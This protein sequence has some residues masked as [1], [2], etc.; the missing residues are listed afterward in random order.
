[1]R[2]F[3]QK[4]PLRW[5]A[6]AYVVSAAAVA[7]ICAPAVCHAHDFWLQPNEF[8]LRPD[9]MTPMTMQ[10]GHGPF[11]QRS[12]IQLGR[13]VHFAA[14]AAD[15]TAIDLRGKLHPGDNT[16][17]A[18]LQFRA[19]GTY[20][21]VLETDDRAQSHLPAI[22][23]NDYLE[24]E[25]LTPALRQ[26]E[27][28]HRMDADGSEN[29]SRRAKSLVQVGLPGTGS[30]AHVT[31]PLG[32]PLEIVPEVSPYQQPRPTSLPVRVIYEGRPL[33]GALLKLTN[34]AEDAVPL[35]THLTDGTGR[36]N[37]RMP[38]SGAWLLN[39]IWTKP[40][41]GSRETDFET[42]FAS[43]SFGLP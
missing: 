31:R 16:A 40:L 21:L 18:D 32:L 15:G 35:E 27:R 28:T 43:L 13:I 2:P 39:V 11:R 34:L 17:D 12:P 4:M 8:W 22:R 37:F 20:V 33:A 38:G 24:A 25:G 3:Q 9:T 36:A 29:Y 6:R 1:M 14:I 42:V 19:P 30:Q 26:R 5:I 7:G 41:P 10:V 23:F